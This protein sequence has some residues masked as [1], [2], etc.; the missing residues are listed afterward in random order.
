MERLHRTNHLHNAHPILL[1]CQR[2]RCTVRV[3]RP[4]GNLACTRHYIRSKTEC[5]HSIPHGC[6]Y[7]EFRLICFF[8]TKAELL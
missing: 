7:M 8:K 4:T 6:L 5:M 3:E 1:S 2:Q